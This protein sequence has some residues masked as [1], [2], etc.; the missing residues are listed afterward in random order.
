MLHALRT[1][2]GSEEDCK[3]PFASARMFFEVL[4]V[5]QNFF[6][7]PYFIWCERPWTS[8]E[9]IS[10]GPSQDFFHTPV[11][12]GPAATFQQCEGCCMENQRPHYSFFCNR[13]CEYF[14]CHAKADPDNFNCLFCYC[15]LYVL[16]DRCG[17]NFVYSQ[18]GV[19]DCSKC[20][21][22]HMPQNYEAITDRY[23]EILS[24]MTPPKSE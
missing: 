15:P 3:L 22:P 21:Y 9:H 13:E 24:A 18:N 17:G 4:L 10:G 19:K 23:R 14:P 16:G 1:Y 11:L 7:L 2:G 8:R 12:R 5:E 6:C 20:L